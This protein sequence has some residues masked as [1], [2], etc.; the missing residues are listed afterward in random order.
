M[1]KILGI[2]RKTKNRIKVIQENLNFEI[3]I[4]SLKRL[5]SVKQMNEPNSHMSRAEVY[6]ALR[7]AV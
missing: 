5:Q 3:C 2:H 1:M 6:T 7:S 4:L